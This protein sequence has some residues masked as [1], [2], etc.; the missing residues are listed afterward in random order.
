M[1][2]RL[3]F[4]VALMLLSSSVRSLNETSPSQLQSTPEIKS[5]S[6]VVI[7]AFV[8]Q[9]NAKKFTRYARNMQ[10]DA[11][12]AL[13][14]HRGLYYVYEYFSKDKQKA[15]DRVYKVRESYQIKDA[16][17]F[18]GQ[19]NGL[20]GFSVQ[21]ELAYG[22][23]AEAVKNSPAPTYT[24]VPEKG[25]S[26][27]I[28]NPEEVEN[29]MLEREQ[30]STEEDIVTSAEPKEKEEAV[31]ETVTET[32]TDETPAEEVIEQPQEKVFTEERP[33]GI[34]QPSEVEEPEIKEDYKIYINSVN[35]EVLTEVVGTV[36]VFDMVRNRKLKDTETHT[37]FGLN[38]PNN[39]EGTVKAVSRIFGYR[40]KDIAFNLVSPESD[41]SGLVYTIGDSLVLDM[42]LDRLKKGDIAVMWNVLYFKD[43][44]IMRPESKAELNS[45]LE[46][47][48]ENPDMTVTLHGHTNG[49]SFGDIVYI[50]END[51][52]YFSLNGDH[53]KTKGSAKK[54]SELRATTI[55][56]W[57]VSNGIDISRLEVK[58]W[59]GDKMLHGKHDPKAYENV[60]VEVEITAD[61]KS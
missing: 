41:T 59:G 38:D 43:A 51:I 14:P 44:A 50:D 30:A 23:Q 27:D 55:Q 7:G 45:L 29:A 3:S 1:R 39:G 16:W 60:R 34:I 19:L 25:E 2:V 53:Q 5:Y 13:N 4:I 52:N 9:K 15:V 33:Y 46:M 12:F 28:D 20:E 26:K 8:F 61:G 6:F 49:N 31:K 35:A 37:L 57:L 22:A 48:K 10:L 56:R 58:G 18:T 32:I 21:P 42:P 36:E 24:Y 11:K 47:L 17:V 40:P 54:L